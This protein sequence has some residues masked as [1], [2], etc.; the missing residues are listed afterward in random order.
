MR[1]HHDLS[2]KEVENIKRHYVE[3]P[4]LQPTPK[5]VKV[6]KARPV[7]QSVYT[8]AKCKTTAFQFFDKKIMIFSSHIRTIFDTVKKARGVIQVEVLT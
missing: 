1:K 8:C 6:G 4:S 3:M 7:V 2:K 5:P